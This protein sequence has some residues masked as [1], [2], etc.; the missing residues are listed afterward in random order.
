[1]EHAFLR[2]CIDKK[3]K[4]N[5]CAILLG[6]SV[7]QIKRKC[8]VLSATGDNVSL[9]HKNKG[10]CPV[11]R[12]ADGV[13]DHVLEC[14][15]SIFTGYGPT[16][17]SYEYNRMYGIKLAAETTR[18]IMISGGA[19]AAKNN[20]VKH[21]HNMR[22]RMACYGEMVQADGTEYDW[23]GDGNKHVML[24]FIDDA[25]SS[26]LHAVLVKSES[27]SSYMQALNDYL[28]KHG[29]PMCLYTDKHGVFRV[30][31]PSAAED[32]Q[33]QF[34]RAM[35]TLDIRMIQAHSAPA[36]GRVERA[37]RTLQDRVPK[38][39]KL[40]G[41]KT[42]EAAN[43]YLKEIFVT[44][45]N[46][47]FAVVPTSPVNAHRPLELAHNL[48][49]I[50]A[51]HETRLI[52]KTHTLQYNNQVVQI[53]DEPMNLHKKEA[54]VITKLDEIIK[55]LVSGKAVKFRVL[56]I[57]PKQSEVACAKMVNLA[58]KQATESILVTNA[59]SA[60]ERGLAVLW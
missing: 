5:Q 17:V 36:K 39:F 2:D 44:E 9:T 15:R 33:T 13:R 50:L 53:M 18:Q 46:T 6:L 47:L 35:E 3:M 59:Q 20:K 49:Q 4:Q 43:Q 10:R 51:I 26:L 25:T 52:S 54:T 55:V 41:I 45:Y 24:V 56:K 32:A 22:E 30:N 48:E 57:R 31:M 27:S 37:N 34:S 60:L 38:R 8:K 40:L 21:V 1:M 29:R 14:C 58:V 16:L 23:L 11:N 28:L 12:I 19:W 7:R 42:L